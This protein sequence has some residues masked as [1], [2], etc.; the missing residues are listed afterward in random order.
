MSAK[1]CVAANGALQQ[2]T[3]TSSLVLPSAKSTDT[4][5]WCTKTTRFRGEKKG[6]KKSVPGCRIKFP[7]G[8]RLYIQ[9][10][11]LRYK[12]TPYRTASATSFNTRTDLTCSDPTYK[13]Q[14][15][16]D[17][18]ERGP[19]VSVLPVHRPCMWLSSNCNCHGGALQH[20]AQ[21]STVRTCSEALPR[22]QQAVSQH[23]HEMFVSRAAKMAASL[24][25]IADKN[26]PSAR[27]GLGSTNA[28][29]IVKLANGA[30][31]Q[32]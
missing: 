21:R 14:A 6:C 24:K 3:T 15:F 20:S 19:P 26:V 12:S 13:S 32:W 1:G 4:M 22:S 29:A 28:V 5:Q 27:L 9:A 25:Q 2:Q 30:Q 10:P 7:M 11:N 18:S 23:K 8:K 31:A 17:T 16:Q